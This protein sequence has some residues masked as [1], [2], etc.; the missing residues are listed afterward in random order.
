MAK[1]RPGRRR[2]GKSGGKGRRPIERKEVRE[3]GEGR[4]QHMKLYTHNDPASLYMGDKA[5]WQQMRLHE[6]DPDVVACQEIRLQGKDNVV[7]A[8]ICDEEGREYQVGRYL[9][10]LGMPPLTMQEEGLTKGTSCLSH[11][12]MSGAS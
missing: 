1:I 6:V 2:G 3:D 7:C 4:W 9:R 10:E 12:P 8:Q 11:C 5:A